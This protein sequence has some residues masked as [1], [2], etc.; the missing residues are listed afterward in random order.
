MEICKNFST[1]FKTNN[2]NFAY[3]GALGPKWPEENGAE[4]RRMGWQQILHKP[5][6]MQFG[7]S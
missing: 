3:C 4:Q 1:Y 6:Y 7:Q 2:N 5:C